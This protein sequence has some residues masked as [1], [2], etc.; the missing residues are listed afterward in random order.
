MFFFDQLV[1]ELS[2]KRPR[3]RRSWQPQEVHKTFIFSGRSVVAILLIVQRADRS[4]F[5]QEQYIYIYNPLNWYPDTQSCHIWKEMHF[6]NHHFHVW[7]L[8]LHY[9][10]GVYIKCIW[11][12]STNWH[13]DSCC[14]ILPWSFHPTPKPR[15]CLAN[16]KDLPLHLF[17][18]SSNSTRQTHNRRP[19]RKF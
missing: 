5:F 11:N 13:L 19:C 18:N 16:T 7:H 6:P 3:N 4:H 1:S 10:L 8:Y 15:K 2:R 17:A 12:V 14:R 9:T